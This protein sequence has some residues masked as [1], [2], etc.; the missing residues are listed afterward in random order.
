[1]DFD[2]TYLREVAFLIGAWLAIAGALWR[3]VRTLIR[4]VGKLIEKIDA[5]EVASREL[6]EHLEAHAQERVQR[7]RIERKVDSV[8]ETVVDG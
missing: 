3:S 8:V 5:G 7:D 2:G 1:M 4:S 6:K